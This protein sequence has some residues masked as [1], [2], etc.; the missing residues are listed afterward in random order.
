MAGNF[1][2]GGDVETSSSMGFN[3]IMLASPDLK[4]LYAK[5]GAEDIPPWTP[6]QFDAYLKQEAVRWKNAI[7]A[8]GI[9][10]E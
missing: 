10:P 1:R 6:A 2:A 9:K 8:A 3:V 7:E 4:D 5:Q